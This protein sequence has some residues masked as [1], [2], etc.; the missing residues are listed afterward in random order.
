M[1]GDKPTDSIMKIPFGLKKVATLCILKHE[2]NLL[3]LKRAK[4]PNKD[5]FTPVGGKQAPFE[6]PLAAA[7]RETHEETGIQLDQ[8]K[9]CGLLTES[10]PSKYNWVNYVY[11]A[12]IDFIS[13]PF[14]NEGVLKWI[15]YA[16]LPE[17]PTPKTD[18]YIYQYVFDQQ[19]FAF[20]ASFDEQLNL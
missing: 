19:P 14:C 15:P 5:T 12:E 10:A 4:E 20:H 11:L 9:Y 18:A 17:I 13:P 6:S 7:I 16:A 3:L 2:D 8:M 1:S